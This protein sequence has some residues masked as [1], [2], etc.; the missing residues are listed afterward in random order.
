MKSFKYEK[1]P[2]KLLTVPFRNWIYVI[3]LGTVGMQMKFLAQGFLFLVK[4]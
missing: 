4:K 2:K 3:I 1:S